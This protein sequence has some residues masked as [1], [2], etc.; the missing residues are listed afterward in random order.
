MEQDQYVAF[1]QERCQKYLPDLMALTEAI[2][3]VQLDY[4]ETVLA[5][6]G[7]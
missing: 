1:E 3:V 7:H 6:C 2:R 4:A 5:R